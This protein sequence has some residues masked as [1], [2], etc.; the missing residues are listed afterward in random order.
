MFSS[1]L[2]IAVDIAQELKLGPL[3]WNPGVPTTGLLGN[4]H[5]MQYI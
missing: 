4:S 2:L 5:L 1:W 3:Q